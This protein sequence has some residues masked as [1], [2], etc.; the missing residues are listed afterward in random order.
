MIIHTIPMLPSS[1]L[2]RTEAYYRKLG[3][4]G[5]S[6]GK[7]YLIVARDGQQLH[8]F[9]HAGGRHADHSDFAC[10]IRVEGLVSLYDEYHAA[11]LAA[12]PPIDQPWGM[13]ELYLVDPDG[14][15][16]RFGEAL[17]S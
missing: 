1:D 10:Y 16:L 6:Q 15:L 2:E 8:F 9:L 4:Q 3:F 7:D 5:K 11:G 13:K 14:S 12:V 17:G